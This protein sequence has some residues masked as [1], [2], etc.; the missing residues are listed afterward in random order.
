MRL[1]QKIVQNPLHCHPD[2]VIYPKHKRLKEMQD[3][4]CM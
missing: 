1:G 2:Q 4:P 3:M